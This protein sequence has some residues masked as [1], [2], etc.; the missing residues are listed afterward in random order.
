MDETYTPLPTADS[1][2]FYLTLLAK[3]SPT[4]TQGGGLFSPG[5]VTP[6]SESPGSFS[7]G[8]PLAAFQMP[9]GP[10][11]PS[12]PDLDDRAAWQRHVM[13]KNYEL[14]NSTDPDI[15]AKALDRI[16]KT[17]VVGLYEERV[18]VNVDSMTR[19][20]VQERLQQL[21]DRILG[22][23][24]GGHSTSAKAPESLVVDQNT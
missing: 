19:E 14:S 8:D 9:A 18:Q 23:T 10:A 16:A 5:T 2:Q 12:M 4:P 3:N 11:E 6:P 13:Q 22:R 21:A 17:S 24:I 1:E 15:V 7:D 20:Q